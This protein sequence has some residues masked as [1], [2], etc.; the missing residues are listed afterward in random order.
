MQQVSIS[1]LLNRPQHVHVSY[2]VEYMGGGGGERRA[3]AVAWLEKRMH[4]LKEEMVMV[5]ARI[6]RMWEG[7]AAL[8]AQLKE[9]G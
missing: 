7:H 2:P 1:V 9:L 5:E 8:K 4:H 6:E 3:E